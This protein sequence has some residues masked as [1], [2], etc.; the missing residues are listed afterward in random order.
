M[1]AWGIHVDECDG[2]LDFLREVG[3]S[4]DWSEVD[5]R[6]RD[7]VADGGYDDGDEALAAAELVAAALG[8]ASPRLAP[9]LAGWAADHAAEARPLRADAV[10]AVKLVLDASELSELW[11]EADEAADWRGTVEE[12]LSRLQSAAGAGQ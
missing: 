6:I 10:A 12:L 2:S 9:E 4:R 1:G 3:D 11:S 7:Y 5:M 8:H